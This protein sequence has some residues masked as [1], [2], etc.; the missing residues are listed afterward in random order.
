[1]PST[2]ASQ[3]SSPSDDQLVLAPRVV[4]Q[5][6][7]LIAIQTGQRSSVVSARVLSADQLTVRSATGVVATDEPIASMF[8]HQGPQRGE[9]G[10]IVGST[11]LML[12]LLARPSREG[13]WCVI[14]GASGL[15]LAATQQAGVDLDRLVMIPNPGTYADQVTAAL[16][17]AFDV[18]V[19]QPSAPIVPAVARRLATIAR[20]C[21]SL[22][23]VNQPD[24]G[25]G[26]TVS[27]QW[28]VDRARWSLRVIGRQWEGI[29]AGQGHLQRQRLDVEVAS[30]SG[31]MGRIVTV[32]LPTVNQSS[33]GW[34]QWPRFVAGDATDD[35]TVVDALKAG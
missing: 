4:D 10:A 5:V 15:G 24:H 35:V 27:P 21:R 14:V 1:M 23:I 29:A 6:R 25:V 17:E 7:Q 16:I 30:K 34:R 33:K 3:P 11:S 18:V 19:W 31:A 28:T 26:T 12:A 32:T 8:A 2:S 20:R 22:L 9:M 13:R